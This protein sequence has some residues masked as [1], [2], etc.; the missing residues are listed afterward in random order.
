VAA[1]YI[2]AN[3]TLGSKDEIFRLKICKKEAKESCL[4]LSLIDC[5]DSDSLESEREKLIQESTELVRI[6]SSI[7]KKLEKRFLD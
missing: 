2:E 3:E 1:N 5:H 4:W 7:V 6:F